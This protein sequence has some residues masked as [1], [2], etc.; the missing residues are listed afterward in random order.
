MQLQPQ[1][2]P[3][4]TATLTTPKKYLPE[5]IKK[6]VK[7]T[8]D[9]QI[10]S[11]KIE[12]KTTLSEHFKTL[13]DP[14][15]IGMVSHQLIDIITIAVCA[16]ICGAEDWV[17]VETFGKAKQHWFSQF[18]ELSNGIPSH[19]TFNSVFNCLSA[20]EL[21]KCF[22][23]W[24]H[25]IFKLT[26]NEVVAIDGKCLRHSYD[27]KSGKAAIHMVSA[28]AHNNRLVLGQVKTDD[29]SNEITA[30]PELLKLLDIRGCIVTI[31][32]M[33]C[34]RSIASEI[35]NRGGDYVLALKGNQGHLHQAVKAYFEAAVAENFDT[36]EHDFYQTTD[37]DHG[38]IETRQYWTIDNLEWLEN[39]ENWTGLTSIGMV[40]RTREIED[41]ITTEISFYITSLKSDAKRFGDAVRAHW[42][43]ENSLHW[44]LDVTFNEDHARIRKGE[45][46][47]NFAVLRHIALNLLKQEKSQKVGIA[48]KRLKAASDEDYLFNVLSL[49]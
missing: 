23:S 26:D 49:Q 48:N 9:T 27:R 40:K 22:A 19:D 42:G 2:E 13:A 3:T 6:I 41:K 30:I 8:Q 33:G 5:A 44:S 28:W 45:G 16:I 31:D 20:K 39:K 21:Q 38:R 29:K 32:A 34:Q 11:A 37:G 14:R 15:K 4:Q 7:E 46:A 10:Q 17:G 12:Y 24:M 36:I 47:E 43:I 35:I 1:A 25:D 18:L